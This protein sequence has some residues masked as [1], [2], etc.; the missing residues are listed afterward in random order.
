MSNPERPAAL[1]QPLVFLFASSLAAAC[2]W[3]CSNPGA[4]KKVQPQAAPA[5]VHNA[6]KEAELATITLT[7]RAEQR[8]GITTTEAV[9][10]RVARTRAYGGDVVLPPDRRTVV[11]APVG[12][13]LAEGQTAPAAGM[14]V[15]RG[16]LLFRLLPHVAPERDLRPQLERD[17]VAAET[18]VEAA[19]VRWERAEQLFRDGAGSAKSAQLAREELDLARNELTAA[20]ARLEVFLAAP[21]S[22]DTPLTISAPRD[23]ILQNVLVNPGQHVPGGAMLFEVADHSA[24]WIRVPV[25]AGELAQ[26]ATGQD[27]QVAALADSPSGQGRK[28]KPVAAPPSADPAASTVDLYFELSNR[29]GQGNGFLR[30]GERVTVRL[31]LIGAQESLTVPWSA[32]L[33]DAN[34]GAWVYENIAP[35]VYTRRRVDVAHVANALAVLNRGPA[36]GARIVTTGA[37]ELFGTEFGAGK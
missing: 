14:T 21:L 31:A 23:G 2:F 12:G 8:L 10:Q 20:R 28:A 3:S 22:A 36:P 1:R 15:R 26:I 25:Y 29:G 5:T 13:T 18:R 30:P 11:T 35:Q 32:V 34:G 4:A 37:L 19:R 27:A 17:L 9:R 16:Q 6:P 7:P 24:V 33:H